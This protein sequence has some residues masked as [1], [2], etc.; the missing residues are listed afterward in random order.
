MCKRKYSK[1]VPIS[2]SS[3]DELLTAG[4]PAVTCARMFWDNGSRNPVIIIKGKKCEQKTC[5]TS[6]EFGKNKSLLE[7]YIM[8]YNE[9]E[10]KIENFYKESSQALFLTF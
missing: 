1:Y 9:C 2:L 4:S 3:Q 6:V 7:N 5:K 10:I 8:V